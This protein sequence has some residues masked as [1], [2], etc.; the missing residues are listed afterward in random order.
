LPFS[1][2][3]WEECGLL[4][5]DIGD[6]SLH[7]VSL[8]PIDCFGEALLPGVCSMV[9]LGQGFSTRALVNFTREDKRFGKLLWWTTLPRIHFDKPTT[10]K[11]NI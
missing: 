1:D 5:T 2:G 11:N 10:N 6:S 8:E 4:L 9:L 3:V 7:F